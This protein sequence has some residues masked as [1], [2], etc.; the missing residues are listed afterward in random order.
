MSFKRKIAVIGL[1][2]VGLAVA[3]AF[4]KKTKV[5]GFDTNANRIA[6]LKKGYDRNVEITKKELNT[7]NIHYTTNRKELSKADFY[8]VTVPTPIDGD[9]RPDFSMLQSASEIIGQFLKKNDIVVYESTVYPGATEEKCLPI[10][11]KKSGLKSGK[12]FFIGYSPERIDPGNKKHTIYNTIKIVS[13]QTPKTLDIIAD[14][15]ASIIE[16]GVHRVSSIKVAEAAKVIENTQRDLNISL[17]NEIALIFHR[18]DIDT[19]EVINATATKW[20]FLPFYPGLVGG[21]CISVDPYYLISKAESVG[22]HPD[23]I[24]SGRRVNDLMAKFIAESAIKNMIKIG[25]SVKKAKIAILGLTYKENTPDLRNSKV[26]D[27]I[28]ELK[29]YGIDIWVNDPLA[30]SDEVKREYDLDLKSWNKIPMV[31]VMIFAVGHQ[32]YRELDL[33]KIM[34]KLKPNGLIMDVKGIF[35][36]AIFAKKKINFWRL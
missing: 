10:L 34:S 30:Y 36:P 27:M 19:A 17:M 12:D 35:D 21:H 15:Y 24:L 33:N 25:L 23:V 26:I 18:L 13:G 16:A 22:Y 20:N 8:I 7:T 4:G 14:V 6:E 1:G 3:T 9:N 32:E 2:Y 31:D 28:H 29:S 5:I 11:E